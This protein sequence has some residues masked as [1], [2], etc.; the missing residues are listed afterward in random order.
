MDSLNVP[1]AMRNS[2]TLDYAVEN[3]SEF[4]IN[5]CDALN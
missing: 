3:C 1:R 4:S 2:V 5:L